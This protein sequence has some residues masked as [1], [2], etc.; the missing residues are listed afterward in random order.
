ME[1]WN[2]VAAMGGINVAN[3]NAAFTALKIGSGN[4]LT[5]EYLKSTGDYYINAVTETIQK[6][7]QEK[8][9]EKE[10]LESSLF[11]EKSNLTTEVESLRGQIDQ[12]TKD[13]QIKEIALSK[14]NDKFVPQM[15]SIDEEISDAGSANSLIVGEIKS[16][17]T[18]IDQVIK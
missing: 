8:T 17:L 18:A 9:S 2:A 12:M 16:V 1:F 11:S 7:I 4:T 5:K 13:L 15:R 6:N 14:I 10:K 3:I